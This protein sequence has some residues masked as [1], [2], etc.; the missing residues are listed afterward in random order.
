M[1]GPRRRA[2]DPPGLGGDRMSRAPLLWCLVAAA[3]FGASTPAAKTLLR[4]MGPLTLAGA[5]Y[6]GAAGF[7][8]L[9]ARRGGSREVTGSRRN[10]KLLAGAVVFG[11]VLGPAAMLTGVSLA[12]AAT[13]ALW[14]NLETPAT[15]M[16][17]ILFFREHLTRRGWVGVV[18]VTVASF[19]LAAPSQFALAPAAGFF[20]LACVC[21]GLDNNFTALI[22]GYTPAQSTFVKGLLAGSVNLIIAVFL[23]EP[24]PSASVF[25]AALLVGTLS[26]GA[27]LVLYVASA[28]HM[29]ATRSQLAFATAPFVGVALS[30]GV[31]RE[32]LTS[33]Q[34]GTGLLM[35]FGVWWGTTDTHRH[36]HRHEAMV[37][38]HWHRHDDGHHEHHHA[39]LPV[40]GWHV[41]E[42]EHVPVE[43]EHPHRSDLHHRHRHGT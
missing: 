43:H 35:A 20:L 22:D 6:L 41:H 9:F 15:A 30:W 33:A 12:P 18:L 25:A 26:Y 24:T 10:L 29:G 19:L 21:W 4:G 36:K 28:Q 27:S 40:G 13:S 37:H 17:G 8:A 14:L 7:A 32:P 1:A 16:L 39:R 2:D 23:G 31:L 34:L 5:L 3:L 11:G 38:T 42:H